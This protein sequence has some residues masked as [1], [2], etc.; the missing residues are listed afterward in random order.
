MYEYLIGKIKN[1]EKNVVTIEVNNIGYNVIV[2][3]KNKYKLE[4]EYKI[5]IMDLIKDNSE[6]NLYGFNEFKELSLFKM[7]LTVNGIGP[8]SALQIINNSNF[9]QLVCFIKNKNVA[10]INKISGVM[11]K[12][13]IICY[14]L[15]NKIKKFDIELFEYNDAVLALKQLGYKDNEITLALSKIESNLDLNSAIYKMIGVIN[16]ARS[17]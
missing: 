10:E 14:E 2:G 3:D 15:R 6:I 11:N 16:D 5:F 1:I 13:N 7:L 17:Q 12:G 8:K 4:E 9:D